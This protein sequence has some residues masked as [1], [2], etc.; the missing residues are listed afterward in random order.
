MNVMNLFVYKI[1]KKTKIR[2]RL[3][4]RNLAIFSMRTNLGWEPPK[5]P[6]SSDLNC[7]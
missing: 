6:G 7:A 2:Y 5:A 4:G 3:H 1:N